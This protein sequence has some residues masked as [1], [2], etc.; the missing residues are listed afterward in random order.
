MVT[1]KRNKNGSGEEKSWELRVAQEQAGLAGDSNEHI[2]QHKE[3]EGMRDSLLLFPPFH[4]VYL[5]LPSPR[6]LLQIPSQAA[7]DQAIPM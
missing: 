1:G 2:I 6:L 4:T 5:L 3:Y 7:H